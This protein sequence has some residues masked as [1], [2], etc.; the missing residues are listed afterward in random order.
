[1]GKNMDWANLIGQMVHHMMENSSTII[2]KGRV[3]MYGLISD[4]I[5]ETGLITKCMDKGSSLGKM[6]GNTKVNILKIRNRVMEYLPGQMAEN[7][8]VSGSMDSKMEKV[9]IPQQREKEKKVNGRMEKRS[10]DNKH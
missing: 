2:L 10:S 7:M 3:Y 9:Y 1:M 6:E 8:K 4:N 5:M